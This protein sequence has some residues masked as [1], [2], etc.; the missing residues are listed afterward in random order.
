[1]PSAFA[2]PAAFARKAR[3]VS[4]VLAALV[5]LGAAGCA[6]PRP[7]LVVRT[8]PVAKDGV[9]FVADGAGNF[10]ATSR[11]VRA[12]VQAERLPLDVI[13]FEWSHGNYRILADQI[14]YAYAR[15]EGC[16]LA[17]TIIR[18]RQDHPDTPIHLMGHSAG[19]MVV[20]AA[21]ES[22][23]ENTVDQAVL[24][25]SSVSSAYDIVP[26]LRA[27]KGGLYNFYSPKDVG[28]LGVATGIVGNSD[29]RWGPSSGRFGFFS[30]PATPDEA[31]LLCKLHQRPWHPFDSRL[32]NFG[33]H[34]G[35]YQPK[36]LRKRVLPI[37][38]GCANVSA[39]VPIPIANP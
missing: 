24:I 38:L 10:Q 11:H 9:L 34:Y 13:T 20:I 6:R 15:A 25:A 39:P 23:P 8:G 4:L 32:G 26:A 18:L 22:L 7:E 28:Y 30:P 2:K 19:A 12:A 27:V 33:G 16:R 1:M 37:F 21:L 5:A 36:F 35:D 3:T 17:R 14:G 29:H 31:Q